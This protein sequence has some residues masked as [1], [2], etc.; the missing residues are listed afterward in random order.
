MQKLFT[1][2][3]VPVDFS[4]KSKKAIENAAVIAM[5]YEC[6]LHL[7]HAIP[8][9]PY[10]SMVPGGGQ[11][12]AAADLLAHSRT[13]ERQ[14]M[15]FSA[16]IKAA[17]NNKLITRYAV[18]FGGW[19]Q[20]VIDYSSENQIDLVV[21]GQKSSLLGKRRMILNP[22][23]IAEKAA[24]PVI[25]IP[26]NKQLARIYSIVI[27]ITEFLPVKKLMYGIYM[28]SH[29]PTTIKLLAVENDKSQ[30]SVQY[31]LKKSYQLIRDNCAV[32]VE[33]ERVHSNNVASAVH[34]F[35]KDHPVD[36][37]ILNPGTQTRMP[38]WWP[39]LF[40]RF[41][42]KYSSPPVLTVTPLS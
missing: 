18:S 29:F 28:G 13:A 16:D 7:L 17:A 42:Q 19:N 31:Y 20:A 1:R 26:A 25:T 30:E 9:T 8:F 33:M 21:I 36:L 40:G 27:P 11:I 3:L 2:L 15:D 32:N 22:D 38:G 34:D 10:V 12:V 5:Q 24:V 6:E 41:I 39:S 35:T 4:T 23:F 37:V 14:L